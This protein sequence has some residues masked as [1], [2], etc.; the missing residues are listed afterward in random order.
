MISGDYTRGGEFT[1]P[2]AR[3]GLS[4]EYAVAFGVR[5]HTMDPSYVQRLA[6]SSSAYDN[7]A[8]FASSFKGDLAEQRAT[9]GASYGGCDRNSAANKPD[10]EEQ[11]RIALQTDDSD[12][13]DERMKRFYG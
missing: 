13:A 8:L 5:R 4:P 9:V 10:G 7:R 1:P 12:D 11:A 3:S 2:D 6:S